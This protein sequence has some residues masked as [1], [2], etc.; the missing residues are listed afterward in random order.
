MTQE[1]YAPIYQLT[2]GT[3]VESLHYGSIAVVNSNNQ[4][5]AWY[6]DP[7]TTTFLRSTAKPFQAMPFIEAGG[8]KEFG[9]TQEEIAIICAS[10]SGTDEHKRVV[11]SI[12]A[13]AGITEDD[14]LCGVHAPMHRATAD[15]LA[16]RGEQPTPNRHNCSGK[17][18]GMVAFARLR[19][20]P[21]RI[22]DLAYINPAHPIQTE[23]IS[24]F[25]QM[26]SITPSEV[27]V[28]IDGCSAPNFAVPLRSAALAFARLCQPAGLPES[29][30]QAC[31]TIRQAMM[32][33][34]FMVAGPGGFDTVLMEV[35]KGKLVCKGGAEGYQ[36]I[37]VM[38]DIL[39]PGSPGLGITYKISDGDYRNQARSAVA[40]EVLRQLNVLSAD[41]LSQLGS[42]GPTFSLTNWRKLEVGVGSPAF[43]LTFAS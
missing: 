19:G 8:H 31:Q 5:V 24:T 9:L 25:A 15:A 20:L 38:P 6:G 42:F 3:I 4:L 18:T 29:R 14:L 40:L 35:A 7:T 30:Q 43:Q 27:F 33:Y 37:G 13:K 22:E 28:G 10:H 41:E 17:H 2:R 11:E 34:P 23:I 39:G 32:T 12:Q 36:G 26:C 1:P 16:S 21:Y